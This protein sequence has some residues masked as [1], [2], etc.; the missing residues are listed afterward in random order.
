[1]RSFS[2]L[3]TTGVS[4]PDSDVIWYRY[5]GNTSQLVPSCPPASVAAEP[6]NWE[7]LGTGKTFT[8]NDNQVSNNGTH[9]AIVLKNPGKL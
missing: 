3:S 1:M 8:I 2:D 4:L 7:R 9:F 6:A 5:K